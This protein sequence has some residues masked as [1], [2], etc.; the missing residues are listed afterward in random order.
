MASVAL[1]KF[2]ISSLDSEFDSQERQPHDIDNRDNSFDIQ[3]LFSLRGLPSLDLVAVRL[4]NANGILTHKNQKEGYVVF[5][6]SIS[7]SERW[8]LPRWPIS[9]ELA[10]SGMH[11]SGL[12]YLDPA[13]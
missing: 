5:T 6:P 3:R 2:V 7:L 1:H 11:L 13:Q 4:S 12:P 8:S 9:K 10:P